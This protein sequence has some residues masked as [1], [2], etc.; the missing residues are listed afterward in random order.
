MSDLLCAG[1]CVC[2]FCFRFASELS[3][4][5]DSSQDLQEGCNVAVFQDSQGVFTEAGV[6]VF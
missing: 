4:S 6:C 2:L 5:S 1:H 3:D